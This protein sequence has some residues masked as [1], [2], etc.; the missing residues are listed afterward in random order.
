MWRKPLVIT[1][2]NGSGSKYLK[3][4]LVKFILDSSRKIRRLA[5]LDCKNVI[6]C[7]VNSHFQDFN[8]FEL[9]F[10]F[11]YIH[12]YNLRLIDKLASTC[13]KIQVLKIDFRS[14]PYNDINTHINT[15]NSLAKLIDAQNKIQKIIFVG[16]TI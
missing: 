10:C 3:E 1:D 11:S 15:Q 5:N 12:N 4:R 2:I 6:S 7:Y 13:K 16:V 14:Y 9:G 8:E